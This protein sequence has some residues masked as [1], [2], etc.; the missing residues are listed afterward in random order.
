MSAEY[1]SI[2]ISGEVFTILNVNFSLFPFKSNISTANNSIVC[3]PGSRSFIGI[4][5]GPL[6]S[7]EL[8]SDLS[9]ENSTCLTPSS[10]DAIP[11]R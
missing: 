6:V 7:I 11:F 8:Y 2:D 4:K 1:V 9:I 5:K 10:S 3:L